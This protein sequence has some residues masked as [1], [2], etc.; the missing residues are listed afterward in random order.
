LVKSIRKHGLID[1]ITLYEGKIVDG[2]NRYRACQEAD[3]RDA[4]HDYIDDVKEWRRQRRRKEPDGPLPPTIKLQ[5]EVPV[6]QV[7]D[8]ADAIKG[9]MIP[10]FPDAVRAAA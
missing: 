7:G 10:M 6:A 5:F 9:A 1:P 2:R 8:V 3:G 4:T